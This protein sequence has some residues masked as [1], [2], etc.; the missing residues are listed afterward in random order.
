METEAAFQPA[1]NRSQHQRNVYFF[2]RARPPAAVD[3]PTPKACPGSQG[4]SSARV[5]PQKARQ[6]GA[7]SMD[8]ANSLQWI[9]QRG[10]IRRRPEL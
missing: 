10:C 5:K 6:H 8:N 1:Q 4:L 7:Y 2:Y 3:R 9:L